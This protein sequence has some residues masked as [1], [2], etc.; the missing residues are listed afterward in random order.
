MA[1]R[2]GVLLIYLALG[3]ACSGDEN[4]DYSLKKLNS[5]SR[6]PIED[7]G[8][9]SI[10]ELMD[11]KGL[12]GLSVAVFENYEIIWSETWGV[13]S[14]S[15]PLDVN[16]AFST[17]S[18][19]K[20]ITATLF[21]ILEEKGMIDL[22]VPVN[23]YLKRW[24]IPE[25]PYT[26]D[27]EVTL[28]HL[29]SHTAG[30]TQHGF[31]DFYEG[32]RIPS[33]LESV[34]GKLPSYNNE[35]IKIMFKPGSDW[36]YSGGGYT[37]AM[38]ALEDHLQ[39]PL[40]DLAEEYL[41]TPL[42]LQNTTMKQPNEEGFL[43]N[44]AKAHDQNGNIIQTGIPIT[45]Q[46]SASGLWSTPTDMAILLIDI[47]KALN[48]KES[49]V[50]SEKVAKRITDIVTLKIM[51]GWSLGWERRYAYGNLD[52]FSHGGA[53]TGIGGHIYATMEN[54]KGV[55]FF[56]NGP[57]SIR[58]PIID[59][60]RESILIAHDWKLSLDTTDKSELPQ[61]LIKKF[62]GRYQDLT[63]G[64]VF[65]IKEKNGKLH[66]PKFFEGRKN[67]L[68]YVGSNS[69]ILDEISGKLTFIETEGSMKIEYSKGS[70]ASPEIMFEKITGK[71]PH[72]LVLE[73]KYEEALIAYQELK[74][75]IPGSYI[76]KESSIN[77]RGYAQINNKKPDIA[78]IFFRINTELYPSSANVWDS[79]AEGY[80]LL[81][82]HENAIKYY[83]KSLELDPGNT[84]AK[85]MLD[86]IFQQTN[87]NSTM[88]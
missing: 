40:A 72:E 38:M 43:E 49:K 27:Q 19:A 61:S 87:N 14:D 81:G 88:Q 39:K 41:F 60:V 64:E 12:K 54:G 57:N 56:G 33:I 6:I 11:Q 53:N 55:V 70:Q 80:M 13:K 71:L 78:L 3:I 52:W 42:G 20:P 77:N 58:I 34:Q 67:K 16:T 83:E 50:I 47:Q 69:F 63:F 75:K 26:K 32:D 66:I 5:I 48:G 4:Q 73:K 24:K 35:E 62:L 45:P 30:T 65:E 31:T 1:N 86:R 82:D 59:Q 9:I 84:N 15:M 37:I 23:D 29:L 17:A 21:A 46:V 36:R 8:F 85:K 7:G 74:D 18:I 44:V 10:Q 28:E 51:R 68:I 22:T 76:V 79:L 2:I 25:S